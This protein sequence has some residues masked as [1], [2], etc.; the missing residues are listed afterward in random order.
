[1]VEVDEEIVDLE[2][3]FGTT[4][5]VQLWRLYRFCTAKMKHLWR[6]YNFYSFPSEEISGTIR[7][8]LSP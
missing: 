8:L 7:T 3:L 5:M 4:V 2:E 6:F 1:M